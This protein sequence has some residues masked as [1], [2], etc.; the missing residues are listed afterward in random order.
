[1]PFYHLTSK[2]SSFWHNFS[3]FPSPDRIVD[4]SK[5]KVLLRF[6]L[7]RVPYP[8][9][10]PLVSW[11]W[12]TDNSKDLFLIIFTPK[13]HCK[14]ILIGLMRGL[15]KWILGLYG[16]FRTVTGLHIHLCVICIFLWVVTCSPIISYFYWA[17]L[18]LTN[19]SFWL[20][21]EN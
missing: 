6:F 8:Y 18:N 21:S 1:M 7:S 15:P 4:Y 10:T 13:K 2:I 5:V 17:P 11:L 9:W 14:L 16:K 20:M 3:P 19:Y 12:H